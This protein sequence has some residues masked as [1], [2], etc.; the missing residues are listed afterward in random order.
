MKKSVIKIVILTLLLTLF[1]GMQKGF[2]KATSWELDEAHA[3]VYF[4]IEHI[5]SKVRG[6]FADFSAKI[7][8]DPENLAES[9]FYFEIEVDSIDTSLGKRDRHLRSED[10]FHE[11]KY[12]KI[13]FQS[14]KITAAGEEFYNVDG[15]LTIKGKEYDFTLPLHFVGVTDHPM[16]KGAQVA[17]FNGEFTL[18]RLKYGVGSGKYYDM[19]VVGKDV[20]LLLTIEVLSK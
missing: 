5:F 18:D 10:F 2:A 3:Y 9:S 4:T 16:V 14:K 13:L 15:V 8:F 20:E 19:G 1:G 17:G 7:Y 11:R 12:P 6:H